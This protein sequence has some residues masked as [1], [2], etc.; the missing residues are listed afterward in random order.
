MGG[1]SRGTTFGVVLLVVVGC[2]VSCGGGGDRRGDGD[3]GLGSADAAAAMVGTTAVVSAAWTFPALITDRARGPVFPTY[4]AHL[5][6]RKIQSPFPTDLV[7]ADITNAGPPVAVTVVAT[8]S[9]YGQDATQDLTVGAGVTRACV[10]PVFDLTKLYALRDTTPGRVEARLLVDGQAVGS[11]MRNVSIAPVDDIAWVD[12]TIPAPDMRDLSAVFVT[13]QDPM[14]DGLQR[15]A[16][17]SSVFGGFGGASP[18]ARAPYAR[19]V[20][21]PAGGHVSE[22]LAVE[23][24][25]SIAWSISSVTGGAADTIDVYLFTPDQLTAWSNGTSQAA[26]MAWPGQASAAAESVTEPANAYFLVLAN[27]GAPG[28][29]DTRT[30]TWSR[31]VT[32]EDVAVDVLGSIFAALKARG[33][34]YGNVTDAY[35]DDFQHIRRASEVL[36]SLSANCID[37]SLLFASTL[38]LL[39]MEPV[40]IVRTG[41]AYVGVKSAPGSSIVWPVETTMVGT[42][43]F[44]DAFNTG[45]DE[46][47]ADEGK[48]QGQVADP[49]LHLVDIKGLRTRGILALPPGP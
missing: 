16:A 7:C 28:T 39:G 34:M 20:D 38:E 19:K 18:Y 5:L 41:H 13:P 15:L 33:T 46:L 42:D 6:G 8:F 48:G 4:M 23:G 32:R 31:N 14:V 2:V 40:V 1:F 24:G 47:L 49:Q 35:F 30:V 29:A 37:G 44:D 36:S 43:S 26:T 25:E 45:V 17:A 11:S 9:V 27:S 22:L 3:A 21:I 12:G 10:T